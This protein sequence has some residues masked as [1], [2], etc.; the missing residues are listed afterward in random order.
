MQASGV[1]SNWPDPVTLKYSLQT[2]TKGWL[3]WLL[4]AFH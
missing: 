2:E 4:T 1:K 3:T